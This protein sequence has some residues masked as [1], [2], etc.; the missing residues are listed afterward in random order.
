MKGRK[1]IDYR[2]TLPVVALRGLVV[3][4]GTTVSFDIARS[5]AIKAIEKAME[6]DREII[7]VTQKNIEIENPGILDLYKVGCVGKVK[8]FAKAGIRTARVM[9]EVRLFVNDGAENVV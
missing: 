1:Y 7:L 8:Q 3:F 9:I 6:S 5:I 2:K 4:P